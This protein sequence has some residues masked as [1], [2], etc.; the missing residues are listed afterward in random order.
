M[1]KKIKELE[2]KL[3]LMGSDP[4]HVRERIDLIN[5]LAAS[6]M[7][8]EPKRA[9]EL[10]RETQSLS[11]EHGYQKGY[12]DGLKLEGLHLFWNA[13][14]RLALAKSREA[15]K[16]FEECQHPKGQADALCVIGSVAA[17]Q[18][19]HALAL[20]NHLK[21]LKIRKELNDLKDLAEVYNSIGMDYLAI[22]DTASALEHYLHGLRLQEEIGDELGQANT[23]LNIGKIYSNTGKLVEALKHLECS[24]KLFQ[25]NDDI[26]QSYV[27]NDIARVY[28]RLGEHQN[29]I[30]FYS[31]SLAISQKA[32]YLQT[33]AVIW[34]NLGEI[35]K[36]MGQHDK[37]AEHYLTSIKIAERIGER[38]NLAEFLLNLGELYIESKPGNEAL[39][40]LE[41][42][43]SIASETQARG[44]A[45]RAYQLLAKAHKRREDH[46]KALLYHEKFTALE[47]EIFS[48]DSEKKLQ[49][50]MVQFEVHRA[51][52]E[53]EVYRL[54]NVELARA[55]E[56]LKELN[57]TLESA[58]QQEKLMQE[59]LQKQAQALE[60]MVTEDKQTGLLNRQALD[61]KLHLEL[62]RTNRYKKP[63]TLAIAEIDGLASIQQKLPT[64]I[65]DEVILTVSG[66][67]KENLRMVDL[68]ARQSQAKFIL[69]FPETSSHNALHVCK[70]IRHQVDDYDWSKLHHDLKITLSIGLSQDITW[71]NYEKEISRT[72][73]LLFKAKHEGG[74]RI[75][76]EK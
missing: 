39:E 14:Y 43:L 30:Q 49:N 54:K 57:R 16:V 35:Y 69:T 21:C 70:R 64:Q 68:V 36:D 58:N 18:G 47:R 4:E 52:H 40:T 20:I 75:V 28:Y 74:N 3:V 1:N 32:D 19:E 27:L 42:A 37:A 11:Q 63:F 50:L 48:E 29:A 76:S 73:V 59:K 31:K 44:L 34:S 41:R 62:A 2:D 5:E 66:L 51:Q 71:E 9:L 45:L 65:I 17:Q 46:R 56:E 38:D 8:V 72:E 55:N 6:L 10:C 33:E 7:N 61:K 12:G 22:T 25:D 60:Q 15:L 53:A 26:R 67:F 23:M 24:L 13:N